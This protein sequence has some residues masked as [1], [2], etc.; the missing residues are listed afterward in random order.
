MIKEFFDWLFGY[1]R[2]GILMVFLFSAVTFF[3]GLVIAFVAFIMPAPLLRFEL[4]TA[5]V[6]LSIF[7]T[8]YFMEYRK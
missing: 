3:I 2:E 1:N 7:A 4:L 6:M 5:T 8:W